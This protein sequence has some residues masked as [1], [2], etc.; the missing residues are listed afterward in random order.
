M[1]ISMQFL[2]AMLSLENITS[3]ILSE[4]FLSDGCK[5]WSR[6]P[7]RLCFVHSE[8]QHTHPRL[9]ISSDSLSDVIF[10]R[11]SGSSR[12]CLAENSLHFRCKTVF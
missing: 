6:G 12:T 10:S 1:F 7:S 2:N 9:L 5:C 8:I 4:D 11:L 3:D